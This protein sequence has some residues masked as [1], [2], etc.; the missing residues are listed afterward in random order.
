MHLQF[1]SFAKDMT[2]NM[3]LRH[4]WTIASGYYSFWKWGE[5][6]LK[7]QRHGVQVN[8]KDEHFFKQMGHLSSSFQIKF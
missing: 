4:T 7:Q 5:S 6:Y 3:K 1:W 8:M 2:I